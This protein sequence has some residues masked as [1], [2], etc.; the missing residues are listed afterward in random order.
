MTDWENDYP[1]CYGQFNFDSNWQ[2]TSW[3]TDRE[4]NSGYP[5]LGWE[6]EYI[7]PYI[8]TN[9]SELQA[10]EDDLDGN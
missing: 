5:A 8:I 4:H 6:Y 3:N 2:V 9:M 1:D 10:M 7:P